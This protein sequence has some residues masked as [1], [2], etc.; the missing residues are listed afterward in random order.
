MHKVEILL[1]V[2]MGKGILRKYFERNFKGQITQSNPFFSLSIQTFSIIQLYCLTAVGNRFECLCI[3]VYVRV[4]M[5]VLGGTDML[6]LTV[7]EWQAGHGSSGAFGSHISTSVL[8]ACKIKCRQ[9]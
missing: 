6:N 4:S 2:I 3:Y 9:C 7:I 5:C 8:L 1:T